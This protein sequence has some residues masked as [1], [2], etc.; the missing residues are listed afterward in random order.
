MDGPLLALTWRTPRDGFAPPHGGD[1]AVH[2]DGAAVAVTGAT[3]V[4]RRALLTLGAPALAGQS[5]SVDYL[6]SAMHPLADAAGAPVPAWT[7]LAAENLT[8]EPPDAAWAAVLALAAAV[9]SDAP[10]LRALFNPG[11]DP[12]SLSLAGAGLTDAHLAALWSPGGPRLDP[13]DAPE[14]GPRRPARSLAADPPA[15]AP[16]L[17]SHDRVSDRRTCYSLFVSPMRCVQPDAP[18]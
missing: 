11:T 2:A 7:D 6:G 13:P 5:V 4:G 10:G 17:V 12:A 9:R 14:V 15:L 3:L 1:F 8:G 16:Q 18:V